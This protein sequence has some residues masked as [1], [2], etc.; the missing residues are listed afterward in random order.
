[1]VY[2]FDGYSQKPLYV[3]SIPATSTTKRRITM[4]Y[5]LMYEDDS[6]YEMTVIEYDTCKQVV[7][8]IEDKI[9][10]YGYKLDSFKV[11][12]GVESSLRLAVS[13]A[14]VLLTN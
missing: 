3:G 9:N 1:M 10:D 8:F 13:P 12:M 2:R 7:A 6:D 14:K 4:K 5:Y 11:V